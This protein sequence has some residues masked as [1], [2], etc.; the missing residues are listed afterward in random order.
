M[1]ADRSK[2]DL[3][4]DAVARHWIKSLGASREEIT[5]AIKKVGPN[6]DT[7]RKELARE[8]IDETEAEAAATK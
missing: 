5:A 8:K 1:S 4:D 6:A 3:T 2:I 7:V